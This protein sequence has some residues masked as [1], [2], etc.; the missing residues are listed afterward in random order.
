MVDQIVR[1]DAGNLYA[2]LDTGEEVALPAEVADAIGLAGDQ[3]EMFAPLAGAKLAAD[4]TLADMVKVV[5]DTQ[6][7][8]KSIIPLGG[9]SLAATA[10]ATKITPAGKA[11]SFRSKKD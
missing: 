2:I 8:L 4:A 6:T 7:T 1:D 3:A 11:S 10:D 9:K 5:T